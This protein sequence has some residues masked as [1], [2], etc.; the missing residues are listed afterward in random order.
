MLLAV[1]FLAF[2]NYAALLPVVPMWAS[3]AGASSALVGGTTGIMMA[4]TVATQLT[5]AWTFRFLSLRRM[6]VIG[7]LLLGAPAPLYLLADAVWPVLALTVVRGVGFALVVMSG[8]TLVADLAAEGRLASAASL[9]GTAAALPNLGALAGGVWIAETAGFALVF[10]GSGAAC[11]VATVAAAGLPARV[12]GA[13]A[14]VSWKDAR[15]ITTP[16]ALFLLTAASFGAA[17]TFLPVAGVGADRA[18]FA[19]LLASITLVLA[20]L[21]A[22]ALADRLGTGRLLLASVLVTAAGLALIAAA[23][24]DGHLPL[25]LTGATAL[26]AGF[27]ACQNDSFVATIRRLGPSRTATGSTIW[28]VAYDGGLGAGAVALGWV[29]GAAGHAGAF[30]TLAVTVGG[31]ALALRFLRRSDR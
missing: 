18:A 26:G 27:G 30:L 4:A 24:P 12:R 20:R 28:N 17:T 11:L 19:L 16:V 7:A 3:A 5:A 1:T 25:L 13:F 9:Y 22:G 21:G 29:V 10:W 6:M 14:P 31:G 2:V 8:A 23:L 15:R